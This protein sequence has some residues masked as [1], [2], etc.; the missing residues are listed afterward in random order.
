VITRH[1]W[2]CNCRFKA[3]VSE[4][5][6]FN[7]G[8]IFCT[9]VWHNSENAAFQY[10]TW[11][12]ETKDS[13]I[14]VTCLGKKTII[15]LDDQ[16]YGMS[17][18][19]K[20]G[21]WLV[22]LD[23]L[24]RWI[25]D[26]ICNR[27]CGIRRSRSGPSACHHHDLPHRHKNY[28]EIHAYRP[29]SWW[30]RLLTCSKFYTIFLY[31]FR[32]LLSNVWSWINKTLG[33]LTFWAAPGSFACEMSETVLTQCSVHVWRTVGQIQTLV[34]YSLEIYRMCKYELSTPRLSKVIVRQTDRQ[35]NRHDQNYIPRRFAGGQ[36]LVHG[37]W[38]QN[39]IRAHRPQSNKLSVF[40]L[41]V[42]CV[43][44][45]LK[46]LHFGD[47]WPWPWPWPLTFDL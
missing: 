17:F 47:S 9:F 41:L 14:L 1:L 34:R 21:I 28:R 13:L 33:V 5:V 10:D 25:T 27:K 23:C 26:E 22:F 45:S 42:I 6:L 7:N 35:A 11:V 30:T 3:F 18:V 15:V 36:K 4:F 39:V 37:A 40:P 20:A 8:V 31:S 19:I 12:K 43:M 16:A 29:K 38:K 44:V 2:L 32:A 24:N 46:W